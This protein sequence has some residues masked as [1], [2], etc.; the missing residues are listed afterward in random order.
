MGHGAHNISVYVGC[1]PLP[2]PTRD[3]PHAL[4]NAPHGASSFRLNTLS[5]PLVL[6]PQSTHFLLHTTATM[7]EVISLNGMF[8]RPAD[9][10]KT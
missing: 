9:A 3:G 1:D 8:P 6:R 10:P 2:K 4:I 7:R 5:R